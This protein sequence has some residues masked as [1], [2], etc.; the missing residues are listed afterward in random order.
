[1]TFIFAS[2]S[3]LITRCPRISMDY[4]F[5]YPRSRQNWI[6]SQ[7]HGNTAFWNFVLLSWI[8]ILSDRVAGCRN[9]DHTKWIIDT[10]VTITNERP[11]N[12]SG[13]ENWAFFDHLPTLSLATRCS[14][15]LFKRAAVQPW[16][17]SRYH[18]V[19]VCIVCIVCIFP[20]LAAWSFI[21]SGWMSLH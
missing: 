9:L 3:A 6:S 17:I 8:S 11:K 15:E 10:Q 19:L 13:L 12:Q 4:G 14:R 16:N 18:G 5:T 2:F 1:M 20:P 7:L 21:V